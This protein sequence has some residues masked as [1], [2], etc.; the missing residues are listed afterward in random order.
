MA[1]HPTLAAIGHRRR[2]SGH[3]AV[4]AGEV[5]PNLFTNPLLDAGLLDRPVLRLLAF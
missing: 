3:I 4:L 1:H 2:E 5:E